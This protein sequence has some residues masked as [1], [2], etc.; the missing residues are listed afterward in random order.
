[1][2][3]NVSSKTEDFP[4]LYGEAFAHLGLDFKN[5]IKQ[6]GG[7][8]KIKELIAAAETKNKEVSGEMLGDDIHQIAFAA[9]FASDYG[10]NLLDHAKTVESFREFAAEHLVS[11][12]AAALD[13]PIFRGGKTMLYRGFLHHLPLDLRC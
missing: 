4:E 13:D 1:M 7:R 9:F 5:L 3:D 6:F 11:G 12:G 8:P 10:Q 2:T